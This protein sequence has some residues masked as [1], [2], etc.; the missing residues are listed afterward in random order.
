M[1][2]RRAVA[3]VL[4]GT[5]MAVLDSFI[6][7]V[8]APA[9]RAD[10]GAS[11]GELQWVLAGYQLT[12]A[13]FLTTGGRLGDLHGRRRV[14]QLGMG[15]FT[16]ASIACALSGSALALVVS[17]LAQGLGAALMVPQV[18]AVI[19]VLVPERERHRAFGVLGLVMGLATIGGQLV[20]GLLIGADLFGSGWRPVFWINVPIG[21]VTLLLAARYV[22]ESRAARARR[23]DVAGVALLSAALF[24]LVYPL[25]QGQDAGWPWWAWACLGASV[26][27][28]CAF[29]AV[30]RALAR[31]GGDPL[32]RLGLFATRSFSVGLV[33]VLAVYAVI[34]SYYLVLSISLQEGLGMSALGAGLVYTPAAV[35]FFSFSLPAGRLVPRYGRRVLAVGAVVLAAGYASTAAVLLAGLPFTPGVVIPTLMLQSVGGGLLITPSLNAVLARVNPDD[36]GTAS[37]VLS[38][39]QQVGGALGVAIIGVVFFNAYDPATGNATTAAHGLAMASLFTL[40]TALIATALVHALP[41][42]PRPRPATK[43]QSRV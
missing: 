38:T 41:T 8:A 35:M 19:T 25:I 3:V 14:F 36:A 28:F 27:A 42:T 24:L 11:G 7:L 37:G 22:P 31:R 32:L 16:L 4:A 39:A 9:I 6:V 40:T 2:G 1:T 10:L 33:L 12:Y 5:F 13:V 15:L 26:P 21:L 29:A 34:T 43:Q 17:R 20:G 18:V 23:I 30:E